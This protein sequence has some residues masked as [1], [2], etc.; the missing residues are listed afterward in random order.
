MVAPIVILPW[1]NNLPDDTNTA[2]WESNMI[3]RA[4]QEK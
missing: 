1:Q 4:N 3:C 2:L